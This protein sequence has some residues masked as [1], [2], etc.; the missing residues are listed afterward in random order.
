MEIEIAGVIQSLR[1]V[2][3]AQQANKH[4]PTPTELFAVIVSTLCS[5]QSNS[6]TVQL[7]EVFL[8]V[9]PKAAAVVVRSQYKRVLKC[10]LELCNANTDNSKLI[11]LCV[12]CVGKCLVQQE[13]S[14][15]FWKT[16]EAM[17]G[18]NALLMLIDDPKVKL[19]K[20]C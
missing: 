9:I 3:I 20:S 5:G 14:A 19:R 11:R 2:V 10:L 12:S 15:P 7:L 16:V 4:E 13:T 1:E 17:K 6:H 18:V 8:A